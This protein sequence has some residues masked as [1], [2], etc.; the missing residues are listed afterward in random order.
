MATLNGAISA[1]AELIRVTGTPPPPGAYLM[2]DDEAIVFHG[3]ARGAQGREF[4]RDWWAVE[5]GVAGTTKA[6]HLNGATLTQYYPEAEASGSGAGLPS[7][8]TDGGHG[9][10]T[11]TVDDASTPLTIEATGDA[12]LIV[13]P[14]DTGTNVGIAVGDYAAAH[15]ADGSDTQ[16]LTSIN[17]GES[18]YYAILVFEEVSQQELFSV[19]VGSFAYESPESEIQAYFLDGDGN[20]LNIDSTDQVQ[21]SIA[22]TFILNAKPSKFLIGPN[23][24]VPL[25]IGGPHAAPDE[26]V[27]RA[28]DL[29]FWFDD[30]DGAAKLMLKGKSANGTVVTGSVN[31]T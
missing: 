7:Q 9:N 5:R 6:T 17:S 22:G 25:I 12:A 2:V 20:G 31:L 24:D 15:L 28:G 23:A 10:V 18:G 29:S 26:S 14:S 3:A 19:Q 21:L 13:V 4:T 11:A 16:I 1:N 27:L 30:T 8:W